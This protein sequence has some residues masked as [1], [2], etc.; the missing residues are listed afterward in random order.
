MAP[1]LLKLRKLNTHKHTHAH[2]HTY[3][4]T[5]TPHV[6]QSLMSSIFFKTWGLQDLNA[7]T[8]FLLLLFKDQN[9]LDTREITSICYFK[10]LITILN[11]ILHNRNLSQVEQVLAVYDTIRFFPY[12]SACS[13]SLSSQKGFTIPPEGQRKVNLRKESAHNGRNTNAP[14]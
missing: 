9:F 5:H 3:T 6:I 8:I 2:T 11:E 13:P 12:L 14:G 10:F 1:I 7:I 4:R